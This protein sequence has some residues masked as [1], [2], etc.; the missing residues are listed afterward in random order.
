MFDKHNVTLVKIFVFFHTFF[1]ILL[2]RLFHPS[3]IHLHLVC[4]AYGCFAAGWIRLVLLDASAS[5]Y[6]IKVDQ[7]LWHHDSDLPLSFSPGGSSGAGPASITT[8]QPSELPWA[9]E[10]S[11]EEA[12]MAGA[13][14]PC[15]ICHASR[16]TACQQ[17]DNTAGRCR[18]SASK[19]Q[20]EG[21]RQK[22]HPSIR[23]NHIM[24][25]IFG[26]GQL[27][28]DRVRGVGGMEEMDILWQGQSVLR[29][30]WTEI[31]IMVR[32]SQ[33]VNRICPMRLYV[34]L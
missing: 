20:D 10:G 13:A 6:P 31:E 18:P 25:K 22:G 15:G 23:G 1:L 9:S 30:S 11:R 7:H 4:F 17:V 16:S 3:Y 21:S 19:E 2:V 28:G 12:D 27:S 24:S 29:K 5:N 32:G 26:F 8:A 33:R 34:S 14:V